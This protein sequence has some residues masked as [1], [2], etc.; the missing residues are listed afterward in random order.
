MDWHL[1]QGE[2]E[3]IAIF[4][5]MFEQRHGKNTLQSV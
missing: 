5:S 1:P 3:H 2:L 4:T